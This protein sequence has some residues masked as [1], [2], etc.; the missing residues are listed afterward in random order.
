MSGRARR[1]SVLLPAAFTAAVLLG[2]CNTVPYDTAPE[3]GPV[4][5]QEQSGASDDVLD[6]LCREA[7]RGAGADGSR[8]ITLTSV[9]ISGPVETID[10]GETCT[11]KGF[12]K[13][14][15]ETF[16][17]CCDGSWQEL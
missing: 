14:G 5:T 15:D 9:A 1:L 11:G 16:Y 2:A 4:Q 8:D 12:G 6:D 10:P 17:K 3:P 13:T 7:D